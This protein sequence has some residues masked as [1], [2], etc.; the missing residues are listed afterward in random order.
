MLLLPM[1]LLV[2]ERK[3]M[4]AEGRRAAVATAMI[5]KRAM[6]ELKKMRLLNTWFA[7]GTF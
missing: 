6:M 1:L 4:V 2:V 5:E 3:A 7:G